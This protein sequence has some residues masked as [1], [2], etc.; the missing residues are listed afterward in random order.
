MDVRCEEQRGPFHYP[1]ANHVNDD[2]GAV[3]QNIAPVTDVTV[4]SETEAVV[5]VL[6]QLV[7]DIDGELQHQPELPACRAGMQGEQQQVKHAGNGAGGVPVSV[8]PGECFRDAAL[9]SV[10]DLLRRSLHDVS[11]LRAGL[12]FPG[13]I[14]SNP[15]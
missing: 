6:F 11:S 10:G 15:L 9:R 5:H 3:R 2:H 13:R 7:H 1:D 14:A 8:E 4:D 12:A